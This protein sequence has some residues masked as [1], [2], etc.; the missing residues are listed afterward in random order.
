VTAMSTGPVSE[1][2]AR[3]TALETVRPADARAGADYQRIEA[4]E[5]HDH[6]KRS[7]QR[8]TIGRV[9]RRHR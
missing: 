3:A 9:L 6:A 8:L 1:V 2:L 7:A 5:L 4:V